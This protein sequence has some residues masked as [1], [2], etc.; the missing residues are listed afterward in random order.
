M[1]TK[2]FTITVNEPEKTETA[3]DNFFLRKEVSNKDLDL[4]WDATLYRVL[5][6]I[7]NEQCADMFSDV[8]LL[9]EIHETHRFRIR[10]EVLK[11][12][13]PIKKEVKDEK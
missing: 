4:L 10:H 11:Q 5:T 9:R 7:E 12:F 6:F 1:K 3:R 2:T 8:E 13:N